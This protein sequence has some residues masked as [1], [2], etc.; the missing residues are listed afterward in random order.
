MKKSEKVRAKLIASRKKESY[1]TSSAQ[2]KSDDTGSY[3]VQNSTHNVDKLQL[4]SFCKINWLLNVLGKREDGYHEV[5]TI[6]QTID[7][8]DTSKYSCRQLQCKVKGYQLREI[9]S[10]RKG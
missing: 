7:L 2:M 10:C 3:L 4:P 5:N 6:L 9:C 8:H 1:Q